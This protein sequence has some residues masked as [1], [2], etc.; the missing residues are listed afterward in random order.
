MSQAVLPAERSE[1]LD[2]WP[3]AELGLSIAVLV[4][5]H[6]EA[7]TIA[8]VVTD[9]RA[10]LPGAA[11]YVYD[12]NSTDDTMDAAR[13]AGAIVRSENQQGK[14]HVVRRMFADIEADIYIMVDGDDT[15]DATA[16]PQMVRMLVE[17][18]LDMVVAVR[19][20]E[21]VAAYRRGHVLGNALLTSAV[22]QFFG[23]RIS[24]VMT[25]LR[26]FS[27]R[28]VK[29]FPLLS[30]VGFNVDPAFS[31]HALELRMPIAEIRTPYRARPE[32]SI[33]KLHT[34]SDGWRVMREI[35]FLV[36]EERPLQ[37]F[38]LTGLILALVGIGLGIP[39]IL[40]YI[41]TRFVTRQPTAILATGLELL[42]FTSFVCGLVL[43]SVARGR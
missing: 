38:A 41:H 33:S 5:C 39:V 10:G 18:Q 13:R 36:K 43:D 11:I 12:N 32:G 26:V 19:V 34:Y 7:V 25:G 24:D 31:I 35:F 22:R 3:A 37:F 14:G 4:P 8:K 9:F 28:Y 17:Q 21:E 20:T 23:N 30:A 27:R 15:Y 40:E 42:A 16:A 1:W 29:S 6:N 2:A